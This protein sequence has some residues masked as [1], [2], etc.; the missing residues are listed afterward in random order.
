MTAAAGHIRCR[1]AQRQH[2][3]LLSTLAS[4]IHAAGRLT[5]SKAGFEM[6]VVWGV[7]AG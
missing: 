2:D 1:C 6:T 4:Y 5:V 7:V 3:L